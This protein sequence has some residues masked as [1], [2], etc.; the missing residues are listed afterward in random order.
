VIEARW[1]VHL[2]NGQRVKAEAVTWDEL[3]VYATEPDKIGSWVL[4]A[5][6]PPP[7]QRQRPAQSLFPWAVVRQIDDFRA[8][9][10]RQRQE[11]ETVGA[12]T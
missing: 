9:F 3:V 8:A 2:V 1:V 4:P 12:A 7:P 10:D 6:A 5:D 11:A